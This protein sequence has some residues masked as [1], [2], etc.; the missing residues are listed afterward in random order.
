MQ[1]E[2][3]IL[4]STNSAVNIILIFLSL[5]ELTDVCRY[6]VHHKTCKSF[7]GDFVTSINVF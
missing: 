2:V 1:K 3:G 4:E 6:G 5:R 7:D